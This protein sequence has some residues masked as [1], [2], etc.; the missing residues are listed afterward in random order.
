MRLEEKIL[1]YIVKNSPN[2]LSDIQSEFPKKNIV[3]HVKML[4]F[5]NLITYSSTL[6]NNIHFIRPTVEGANYLESKRTSKYNYVKSFL[7]RLFFVLLG[8]AL[9][10]IVTILTK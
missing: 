6:E 7:D 4:K 5:R 10:Y 8:A 3:E 1:L 2:N 9:T